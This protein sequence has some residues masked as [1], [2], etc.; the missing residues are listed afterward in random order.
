MELFA[1]F[2]HEIGGDFAAADLTFAQQSD[3]SHLDVYIKGWMG[4]AI[5]KGMW[6]FNDARGLSFLHHADSNER[7]KSFEITTRSDLVC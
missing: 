1:S 7:G 2:K 6:P 3:F 5:F 4:R